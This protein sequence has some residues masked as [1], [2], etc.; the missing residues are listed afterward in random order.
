MFVIF[1]LSSVRRNAGLDESI[2]V[3]PSQE[4][5]NCITAHA[6]GGFVARSEAAPCCKSGS[7]RSHSAEPQ[8]TSSAA[9]TGL[10]LDGASQR[11]SSSG[12][13]S[14]LAVGLFETAAAAFTA[15]A[16][17][18]AAAPAAAP[19]PGPRSCSPLTSAESCSPWYGPAGA[20]KGCLMSSQRHQRVGECSNALPTGQ[21]CAQSSPGFSPLAY[22]RQ[23]TEEEQ[24]GL[25][26]EGHGQRNYWHW[27]QRRQQQQEQ[28]QEQE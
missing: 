10:Q 27:A 23:G 14:T 2:R 18:A 19:I 28:E 7:S 11:N 12:S 20:S 9:S 17:G 21:G 24:E 3:G 22:Q 8:P 5:Q 15:S 6:Q 4:Q 16:A 26:E 25:Q 1:C 13:E